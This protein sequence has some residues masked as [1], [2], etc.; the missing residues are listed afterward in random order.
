MYT[1]NPFSIEE[2]VR[3]NGSS[4]AIIGLG[5]L[6]GHL[7]EQLTRA[8]IGKLVLFDMDAF[9]PSNLNR[10]RFAEQSTLGI[11]KAQATAKALLNIRPDL[12]LEVHPYTFEPQHAQQLQTV[13]VVLD[14]L[15]NIPS[16]LVL[17]QACKQAAKVL[18]HGAVGGWMGQVTTIYPGDDFLKRLY[19]HPDSTLQ[20]IVA[21]AP[22]VI[23]SLQVIQAL[24]YLL[25]EEPPTHGRLLLLDLKQLQSTFVD[26]SNHV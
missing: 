1:R 9:T 13:D 17:E 10:Q 23:A 5:G 15:D 6:G 11:N 16:R 2:Q 22:A 8:G 21:S 20:R 26:W 12:Q 24:Q 18:I 7:A 25:G 14:G 4:A 19:A 3:I